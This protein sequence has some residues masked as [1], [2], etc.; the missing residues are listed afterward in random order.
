M[1]EDITSSRFYLK[2]QRL[3]Q[4]MTE[5]NP[6]LLTALRDCIVN[7]EVNTFDLI[8]MIDEFEDEHL[9]VDESDKDPKIDAADYN[10]NDK[11]SS[12]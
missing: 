4:V 11:D 3:F 10:D 5:E 7:S 9:G 6:L 1:D 12:E 2:W 8:G